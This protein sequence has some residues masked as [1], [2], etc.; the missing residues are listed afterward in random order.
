MTAVH[1][2]FF[3]PHEE[4]YDAL[5]RNNI[6]FEV[7]SEFNLPGIFVAVTVKLSSPEVRSI[8]VVCPIF[9]I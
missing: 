3:K 7:E 8:Q 6:A 4:L 5:L 2:D 1:E 9:L